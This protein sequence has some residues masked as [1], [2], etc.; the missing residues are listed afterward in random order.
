[1]NDCITA[2]NE[3]LDNEK[4]TPTEEIPGRI[5]GEQ[6]N[7]NDCLIHVPLNIVSDNKGITPTVGI[8]RSITEEQTNM[9]DYLTLINEASDNE[10]ITLTKGITGIIAEEHESLNEYKTVKY[11]ELVTERSW[12]RITEEQINMN[13]YLSPI[14][15]TSYDN[16][17]M[18]ADDTEQHFSR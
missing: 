4:I 12:E 6:I 17:E 3:A 15:E 9:N 11:E 5:T 16:K 7:M 8:A 10:E 1:M 2:L 18:T 13:D 14:N